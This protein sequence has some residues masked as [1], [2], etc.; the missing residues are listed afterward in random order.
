MIFSVSSFTLVDMENKIMM[1]KNEIAYNTA[2][3]VI[4]CVFARIFAFLSLL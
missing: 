4:A 3:I 2:E 1:A